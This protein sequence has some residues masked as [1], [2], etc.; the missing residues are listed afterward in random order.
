[1]SASCG[2]ANPSAERISGRETKSLS[3]RFSLFI[4]FEGPEGGGKTTQQEQLRRYLE[5]K[6]LAPL[7]L[8]EP[9]ATI[10]SERIR[11]LLLDGS[12]GALNSRTEALLFCAARAELVAQVIRPALQNG[13]IVLCDRYA[14]S[15]LAYQGYGQGL[16]LP[17]LRVVNDF[18]TGGL[19]PHLT[20]C[21][22]VPV[23][24]G[25]GRK[26]AADEGNRME[27][28]AIAFHERVR[29]GFLDLVAA[30]PQRWRLIDATQSLEAV[31][32]AIRC[33]VDEVLEEALRQ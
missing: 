5:E 6:G 27:A 11:A 9:G 24:L 1:M 4:T 16:P 23:E 25:L 30:E 33:Y 32:A 17:E 26:R 31:A 8:R 28:M 21:L 13:R 7:C 15:T 3:Q 20:F 18:A 2:R 12:V 22:D 10:V 19:K 14:D 29:R